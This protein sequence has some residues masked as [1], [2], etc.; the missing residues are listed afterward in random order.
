MLRI[1]A[2][3]SV[4]AV[5]SPALAQEPKGC[6]AFKWPVAQEHALL[7]TATAAK[8]SGI[9]LADASSPEAVRIA[10]Q[11]IELAKLPI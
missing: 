7:R 4:A 2:L 1:L 6:D 9:E 11:P 8:P 5:A 10:L 3:L